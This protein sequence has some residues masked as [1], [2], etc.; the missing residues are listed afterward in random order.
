MRGTLF[1]L[2]ALSLGLNAGMLFQRLQHPPPFGPQ[3]PPLKGKGPETPTAFLEHHLL[4]MT[5]DLQLDEAQQQALTSLLAERI[6]PILA[7]QERLRVAR[8]SLGDLYISEELEPDTFRA[9]V[10]RL[11]EAQAELDRLVGEVMVEE[12]SLLSYEQRQRYFIVMPWGKGPVGQPPGVGPPP[13][14]PKR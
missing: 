12:A 10:R 5:E 2:L 14:P 13:P 6:P 7:Q 1:V 9:R 4:R 3:R 11:S 8:R